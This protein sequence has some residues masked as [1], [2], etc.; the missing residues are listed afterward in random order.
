MDFD[1]SRVVGVLQSFENALGSENVV[2]VVYTS[3]LSSLISG[4]EGIV[5]PS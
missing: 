2:G 3:S 1:E 4:V 5:V